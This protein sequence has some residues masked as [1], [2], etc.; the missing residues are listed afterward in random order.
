[1]Y[2][3]LVLLVGAIIPDSGGVCCHQA[4]HLEGVLLYLPPLVLSGFVYVLFQRIRID[5]WATSG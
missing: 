4:W 1:M 3:Q 2:S 5:Q